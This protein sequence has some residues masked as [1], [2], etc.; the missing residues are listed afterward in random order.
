MFSYSN[1][2]W[3]IKK[4][5]NIKWFKHNKNLFFLAYKVQGGIPDWDDSLSSGDSKTEFLLTS[6]CLTSMDGIQGCPYHW[7]KAVW[8]EMG[9]N[10]VCGRVLWTKYGE[11][12]ITSLSAWKKTQSHDH[13]YLQGWLGI[14]I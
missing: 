14:I 2:D 1:G 11:A 6:C 5:S 8:R 7:Q 3:H 12:S 10:T 13:T 4:P 9:L